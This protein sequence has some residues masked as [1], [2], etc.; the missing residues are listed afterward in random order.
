MGIFD[1]DKLIVLLGGLFAG[2]ELLDSV[3]KDLSVFELTK[4][5]HTDAAALL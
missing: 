2:R 1:Q 5:L 3:T 4:D